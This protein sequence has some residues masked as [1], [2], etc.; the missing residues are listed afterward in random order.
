MCSHKG[1]HRIHSLGKEDCGCGHGFR[2]FIS[3]KE[4]TEMLKEYRD[5]LKNEIEG[6]EETIQDLENK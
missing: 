4:K 2:H 5:Q 1:F 6:L 3:R